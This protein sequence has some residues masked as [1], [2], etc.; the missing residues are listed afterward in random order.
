MTRHRVLQ[1]LLL[2]SCLLLPLSLQAQLHHRLEV[3]LNPQQHS[4]KV[5]DTITRADTA[6]TSLEIHLH[7][8][9]APELVGSAGQLKALPALNIT[10]HAADMVPRRYRVD[11]PAGQARFVL[12]HAHGRAGRTQVNLVTALEQHLDQTPAVRDA[13]AAAPAHG[14]APRIHVLTHQSGCVR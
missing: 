2:A 3:Q 11:L 1:H 6:A 14:E 10:A 7:P 5:T 4:I 9:L 8:D 13:A 12:E